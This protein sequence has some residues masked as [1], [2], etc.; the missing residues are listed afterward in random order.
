VISKAKRRLQEFNMSKA[1]PYDIAVALLDYVSRAPDPEHEK[2]V[3]V[4][5]FL[6]R[7][8]EHIEKGAAPIHVELARRL[9]HDL[10]HYIAGLSEIAFKLEKADS[11]PPPP[12]DKIDKPQP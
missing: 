6:Q 5:V 7:W 9:S 8:K 2:T 3:A 12:E 1:E 10:R 11:V 4:H